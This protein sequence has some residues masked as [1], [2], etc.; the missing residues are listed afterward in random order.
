LNERVSGL[1]EL[2]AAFKRR[3]LPDMEQIALSLAEQIESGQ[4][5][6]HPDKQAPIPVEE[7]CPWLDIWPLAWA[8]FRPGDSK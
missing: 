7:A 3:S 1:A 5:A 2:A 8:N 4:F 6:I